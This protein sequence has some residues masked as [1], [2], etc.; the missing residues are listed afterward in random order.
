MAWTDTLRAR[1]TAAGEALRGALPAQP[2]RLPVM[3]QTAA[4][5]RNR[6]VNEAANATPATVA[7]AFREADVGQTR[8]IIDLGK[9]S[10]QLD[11][12]LDGVGAMRVT[13]IGSRRWVVKPALG[14]EKDPLHLRRV[15]A[16]TQLLSE[17]RVRFRDNREHLAHAVLEPHGVLEHD[18]YTTTVTTTVAGVTLTESLWN[19]APQWRHPRRFCWNDSGQIAKCDT[20]VDPTQGTPLANYPSKFIIHTPVAG[21]S[22]YPWMRGALRSRLMGSIAKRSGVKWW[23]SALE[24]YGQ[25]QVFATVKDGDQNL[26]PDILSALRAI[27][28]DW[29]AI[30]PDGVDLKAL[31]VDINSD[32]HQ[33][34]VDWQNTED[35]VLI[36]GQNLSTEVKGGSYAAAQSQERVRADILASDLTALDETIT[37]QWLALLWHFNWPGEPIG[38]IETQ[39]GAATPYTIADYQAGLCTADEY[40]MDNGHDPEPDGK[41]DRY[42]TQP[43]SYQ[44]MPAPGGGGAAA[45]FTLSPVHPSQGPTPSASPTSSTS[46]APTHPLRHALSRR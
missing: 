25:P 32:L 20:G 24:R 15:A 14:H 30:L 28:P 33:K 23:L 10:R 41:G 2:D 11:A 9:S 26:V 37:D 12:R 35:A 44:L 29:R 13:V 4:V 27:G 34:F 19:T 1:L 18:W 17:R 3:P 36:L 45:P 42:Y 46:P 7:A 38:Y 5:Q 22:N 39:V 8:R 16:V 31:P 40:R 21:R 43:S 6:P